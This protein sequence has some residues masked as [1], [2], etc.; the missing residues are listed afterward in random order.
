MQNRKNIKQKG[1]PVKVGPFVHSGY[2]KKISLK[3]RKWVTTSVSL[4]SLPRRESETMEPSSSPDSSLSRKC[5]NLERSAG[6][7][8]KM[9][10][11]SS[12]SS[13]SPSNSC[14]FALS[15]TMSSSAAF[16]KFSGLFPAA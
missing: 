14:C 15:K 7:L 9:G 4:V 11:D 2:R 3:E 5:S 1:Q 10:W 8:A 16:G 13:L 12:N 6:F